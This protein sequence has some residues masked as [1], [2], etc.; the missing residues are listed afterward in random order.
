MC[1]AC[2]GGAIGVSKNPHAGPEGGR[3]GGR[4]CII[5]RVN[6]LE[7]SSS[8]QSAPWR[9]ISVEAS[10]TIAEEEAPPA[11]WRA[12]AAAF[13]RQ[14]ST[15]CFGP[16]Q[17]VQGPPFY[18]TN[19]FNGVGIAPHFFFSSDISR[20]TQKKISV[21]RIV[22]KNFFSTKKLRKNCY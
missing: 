13:L 9:S 16:E 17:K 6:G 15:E 11:F 14:T 2:A 4:T 22:K 5:M 21:L 8:W 3:K 10:H 18:R 7:S 12:M 1:L 20:N 19:M